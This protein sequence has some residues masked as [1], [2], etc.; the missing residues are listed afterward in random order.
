MLFGAVLVASPAAFAQGAVDSKLSQ[1][2]S[3]GT[4]STS[5]L[6]DTGTTVSSPSF[7]LSALTVATSG[8]H[9]T[10]TGTFGSNTQRIYVDN[11]GM[12]TTG[13][14]TLALAAKNPSVGWTS[15]GTTKAYAHNGATAAEGQL[16]ITSA[17][18][19]TPTT[20]SSTGITGASTGTFST[21]NT[22]FTIMTGAGSSDDVWRGYITGIGISQTVPNTVPAGNYYI[23]LTQTLTSA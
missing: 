9:Q 14:W 23:D 19:V 17:G 13:T 7:G 8:T 3:A 11:P 1:S 20:G 2:I 21:T 18:T 6:S 16:S 15:D 22:S 4:L 10:S 12:V 5:I